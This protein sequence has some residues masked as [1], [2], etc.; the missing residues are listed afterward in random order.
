MNLGLAQVYGLYQAEK[1]I[2][3]S[4]KPGRLIGSPQEL[5]DNNFTWLGQA[6]QSL[7]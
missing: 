4:G 2:R 7:F 3:A 5:V 1:G 6:C